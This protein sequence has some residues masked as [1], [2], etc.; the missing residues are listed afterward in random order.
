MLTT[1]TN[2][3]PT[4]FY[5]RV[6]TNGNCSVAGNPANI[7]D[8][9]MM[10]SPRGSESDDDDVRCKKARK[11]IKSVVT[12]EVPRGVAAGLQK[13]Y[14]MSEPLNSQTNERRRFEE[15]G[16][17]QEEEEEG[18]LMPDIMDE[19]KTRKLRKEVFKRLK[20]YRVIHGLEK[21]LGLE[22]SDVM[23]Y[24]ENWES[25]VPEIPTYPSYLMGG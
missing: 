6:A 15:S 19:A 3:S 2:H 11:K 13:V 22:E 9:G 7:K 4:D 1:N 23:K 17:E 16:S 14:S 18:E 10:S 24:M 21:A 25:K 20:K 5:S 12:K 8:D